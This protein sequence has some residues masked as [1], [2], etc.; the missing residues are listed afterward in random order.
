[1]AARPGVGY[2]P[3]P[4]RLLQ[5]NQVL[6]RSQGSS[7]LCCDPWTCVFTDRDAS[8]VASHG[9]DPAVGISE[10]RRP[11]D[12][13]TAR[14]RLRLIDPARTIPEATTPGHGPGS[15]Q[16]AL[17]RA[18]FPGRLGAVAD[19]LVRRR[20]YRSWFYC[21]TVEPRENWPASVGQGLEVQVFGVGGVAREPAVTWSR[22]LERSLCYSYGC[23]EVLE[24]AAPAD[25][26]GRRPLRRAGLD[27]LR[28]GVLPGRARRQLPRLLLPRPPAR[29]GRR[30]RA[31]DARRP[32]STGGGRWP[33]SS[34]S[35]WSRRRWPGRPPTGSASSSRPSTATTSWSCTT[36]S[37]PAASPVVLARRGDRP[38]VDRRPGDPRRDAGRQLRRPVAR[39]APRLRPIPG[40]WPTPCC[41]PG[42]TCSVVVVGDPIVR[43]GLD[44]AFHNQRLPGA[45]AGAAAARPIPSGSGSWARPR[46]RRSPRSWPPATCTSPRA[47]PIR[48]PARCSRRWR[49]AASCWP[50]TPRR[51]ARSSA[52]ARPGCWSTPATRMRWCGRRWPSWTT[53]PP[54]GRWATPRPRWSGRGTARTS[55]CPGWP[56]GSTALAAA[57]GRTAVNVLFIH[58]AF[59]AQFGRLGLELTDAPRLAVQLPGAEPL[60]LPDPD[61]RDA[62]GRSRCTRCR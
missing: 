33:R 58:D 26:P 7:K 4:P 18:A 14:R 15:A 13:R 29:P 22:A 57:G 25:R 8:S 51:T 35:T 3:Q 48:S 61:A 5:D 17:G 37:T 56:S 40:G 20:G 54:T 62:P 59:P 46:P 41:G 43:R 2:G 21:H 55:A 11:A 23:W 12:R 10:P 44:V 16:R 34:C 31:R 50:P 38:A 39:P 6:E 52:T 49:P 30:G 27:P 53:R 24:Q 45:P 28:A 47:G 9:L 36:A 42:P 1:M 19:W 32:T 60:E